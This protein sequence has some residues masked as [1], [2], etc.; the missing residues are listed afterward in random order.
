MIH[1]SN[2]LYQQLMKEQERYIGQGLPLLLETEYLFHTAEKFRGLLRIEL[3]N[4]RFTDIQEEIHFFKHIKPK[5][6]AESDYATLL[7]FA[8]NFC[9]SAGD[10]RYAMEFWSRQITRMAKFQQKYHEFFSYHSQGHAHL[11]YVHYTRSVDWKPGAAGDK[12]LHDYDLLSGRL[13]AE[14]RYASYASIQL[15]KLQQE[16]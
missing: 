2:E 13:A 6:V 4:Y 8:G 14:Q 3:A 9:P 12:T 11:D 10:Q 1:R 16:K 15:K 7:N 5:F